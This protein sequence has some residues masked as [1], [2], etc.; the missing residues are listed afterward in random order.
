MAGTVRVELL[1]RYTSARAA[2]SPSPSLQDYHDL[3]SY[4]FANHVGKSF[5]APEMTAKRCQPVPVDPVDTHSPPLSHSWPDRRSINKYLAED[6]KE[7]SGRSVMLNEPPPPATYCR[8]PPARPR[9]A[10][11]SSAESMARLSYSI[12]WPRILGMIQTS[13]K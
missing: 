13:N 12:P 5:S 9:P 3:D 7:W 11:D 2:H 10:S 8:L 4:F 6:G 1:Y